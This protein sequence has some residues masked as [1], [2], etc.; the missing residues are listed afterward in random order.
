MADKEFEGQEFTFPDE[1]EVT[2]V[3]KPEV[4]IEASNA[5]IEIEIED[6]TPPQDRGGEPLP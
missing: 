3:E 6:D 5:D 2:P 4:Q 1:Q